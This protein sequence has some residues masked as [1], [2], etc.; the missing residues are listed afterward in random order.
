[1][2]ISADK[3]THPQS[4]LS[5]QRRCWQHGLA[6]IGLMLAL[7]GC[8]KGGSQPA[9]VFNANNTAPANVQLLEVSSAAV[10]QITASWLPATDEATPANN[11][12]YQLHASTD[13]AFTPSDATKVFEGK[14]VYQTTVSTGLT[15]GSRYTVKLVVL[16]GQNESTSS[17]SLSVTVAN[18]TATLNN[19]V[20]VTTLD[21]SQVASIN[22]NQ[23]TLLA[24]GPSLQVGQ[25]IASAEGTSGNGYLKKIEA[26][27]TSNGNTVL[28]T[29][30]ASVNEVVSDVSLSSSFRLGSVPTEVTTASSQVGLVRRTASPANA[31]TEYAWQKTGFRYSARASSTQIQT[32]SQGRQGMQAGLVQGAATDKSGSWGRL[33]MPSSVTVAEGESAMFN[34]HAYIID[35]S[36]PLIG[37][38]RK[39]CK[40]DFGAMRGVGNAAKPSAVSIQAGAGTVNNQDAYRPTHIFYPT[41]LQAGA[42]TA[43]SNPYSVN[44]TLYIEPLDQD[45][46][47]PSVWGETVMLPL[48]IYVTSDNAFREKEVLTAQFRGSGNFAVSNEIEMSFVPTI[49]FDAEV[50][51]ARLRTARIQLDAAPLLEQT[52]KITASAQGSVDATVN[53][54]PVRKF[55]KVYLTPAGLPIVISGAYRVD[56]SIKG[57]VTGAID[58]TEKLT[59]GF[60]ELS[61]GLAY[62]NGQYSLINKRQPVYRLRMGG[63]GKAQANL[64]IA[65]QPR[66]ELSA[67]EAATGTVVLEPFMNVQAGIEGQVQLDTDI[68]FNALQSNIAADADFRLTR[69]A[70]G[71][72]VRAKL[73]AELRVFDYNI[74]AWPA[75]GQ[76]E[77][78][79]L[80]DQ[81]DFWGLPQLEAQADSQARHSTDTRALA[82]QATAGNVPNTLKILFPTLPNSFVTWAKWTDPRIVP[83]LGVPASS[84]RFVAAPANSAPTSDAAMAWVVFKQPGTYTVRQGGHS[85]LGT[86]ARQYVETTIE[87]KDAN[88]NGIPDWWEQRYG[89][90]GSGAGAGAGSGTNIGA[91][92][93]AADPDDDGATNLQEWNAGTDPTVGNGSK[94]GKLPHTGVTASVC[95]QAG[96]YVLVS[97]TS[98]AAISLNSQQDGMRTS[99][100]PMSYSQV[101]HNGA[102]YGKEECVK[103]NVTGLMWEGKTA[104]GLRGGSNTYTNYHRDFYDPNNEMDAAT[105]AYGY[106]AAVNRAGLCGYSDW[107]LPTVDELHG[108]ANYGAF[109]SLTWFPNTLAQPYWASLPYFGDG[110]H[111]FYYA[112]VVRFD[113]GRVYG[114]NRN[115]KY[116]VRLVRASQ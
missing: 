88:D 71:G 67:Y 95:H 23:L 10:G 35:T 97:C 105:N 91:D 92:L 112:W 82:I 69:G 51:G 1:M 52:L 5:L 2:L 80:I 11:L 56:M 89:L 104:S 43:S 96:T 34:I 55:Y 81:T 108:I 66:L 9:E 84:Y 49:A 18:T 4:P 63:Q 21:T 102:T 19:G 70:L 6:V 75:Q 48:A 47:N 36:E 57:N 44:V 98:S 77:P 78:Y 32:G 114:L 54:L 99:V 3:N 65:L 31:N 24:G 37:Q 60:D 28:T 86:W 42:A 53:I 12:T 27:T 8:G 64:E 93:A 45:C 109:V 62:N 76:L 90:T 110:S 85:S 26:I 113:D 111:S 73:G 22:G 30:D 61:Y 29:R 103:D 68:D 94:P 83:P 116:P 107:R 74:A 79:D 50:S 41:T 100:N 46:S 58:A 59:M 7:A 17:Q 25:F 72:G 101:T 33:W 106:V 38:R 13:P 15:A 39:I 14:A 16:D 115:W 40:I 87:I 20:K